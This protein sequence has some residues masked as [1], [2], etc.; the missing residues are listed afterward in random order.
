[1]SD[2]EMSEVSTTVAELELSIDRVAMAL[3]AFVLFYVYGELQEIEEPNELQIEWINGV[4]ES[5]AKAVR[6][7]VQQVGAV[8]SSL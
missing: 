5:S 4:G 2:S 3:E 6:A 1:M 8:H 7:L